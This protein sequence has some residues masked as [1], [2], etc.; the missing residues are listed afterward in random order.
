MFYGISILTLFTIKSH[1]HCV[2]FSCVVSKNTQATPFDYL[3]LPIF[4]LPP[5][6]ITIFKGYKQRK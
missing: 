5:T 2:F 4:E 6:Y 1:I 3:S